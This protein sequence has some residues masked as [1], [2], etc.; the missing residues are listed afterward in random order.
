MTD[1]ATLSARLRER[2]V[3]GEWV[4]SYVPDELCHEAA[5]RLDQL[6]RDLAAAREERDRIQ[7]VYDLN[8]GD[9]MS[10]S[11]DLDREHERAEEAETNWQAAEASL[12]AANARNAVLTGALEDVRSTIEHAPRQILTDTLWFSE[13]ETVVDHINLALE[14]ANDPS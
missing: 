11:G 10:L 8:R 13:I 5:D 2:R 6:S 1:P 12:A 14:T 3:N 7:N 4:D 9:V